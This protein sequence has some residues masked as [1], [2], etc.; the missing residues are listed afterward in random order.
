MQNE[1][2]QIE[3]GTGVTFKQ[4]KKSETS[5]DWKGTI[6]IDGIIVDIVGW[7]TISKAGTIYIK[8]RK[9]VKKG[10]EPMANPQQTSK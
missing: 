4:Q 6:N 7:E 8:W 2:K 10:G 3:P 5:P 1:K 9:D